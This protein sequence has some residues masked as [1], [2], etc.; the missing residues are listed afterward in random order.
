MA[1]VLPIPEYAPDLSDIAMKTS[2]LISG[3]LPRADGYG[4][5]KSYQELTS[6]LPDVCRGLFYA[7]RT[8]SSIAVFGATATELYLLNNTDFSWTLVSKA[9]YSAV[10]STDNWQFDQF[11]D[12]VIATQI[13]TPPQSFVLS[14]SS[15]FADLGGSPPQA[16]GVA[17]IGG[18]LVLYGLS[19]APKRVQ[20]SDLFAITTW[21]A[22]VGLSD[23]QDFADGGTVRRVAGGDL[24]GIV[25]QDDRIRRMLYQPGSAAIFDFVVLS[26]VH[27]LLGKYSVVPVGDQVFFCSGQGFQK[28]DGSGAIT[29][30]GKE[31]VDRTFLADVDTGNLQLFQGTFDPSSTRI[32]WG[33]KSGA[34][35]SGLFDKLLC[36]DY[37]LGKLGKWS[38]I[39]MSGEFLA[40]VSKPGLTLE[41]LDAIAPTPLNITG[42]ANNGSGAIRLTLNALSN[43]NF[44]IH[45]QNFITVY[46]VVGTTEANNSWAFTIIDSTHIDLVGSTFS[47]AYVSGGHIGGSLDALPFSLDSVSTASISQVAIASSDHTVGYFSGPNIEAILETQEESDDQ[48]LLFLSST[49][50]I[51][52]CA[53]VMVSIG[54]RNTA[55]EDPVYSTENAIDSQQ[56]QAGA[57]VEGRYLKARLRFPAGSTWTYAN[58]VMPDG[59]LAGEI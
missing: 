50:P 40:S 15:Q 38:L 59:Q 10:P 41:N 19:S 28:I 31:R 6:S 13:N 26:R 36:H 33:Y 8:D 32:F 57:L 14:S 25:F 9:T 45:G 3:A 58:G 23:Y 43:S 39:P 21:T 34:G 11:N 12:T 4:P 17:V 53:D 55:Q 27:S 18:F 1:N 52:D 35:Q 37:A 46:G 7:R 49:R 22:G 29:P 20:W 24:F 16:A 5:F 51:T 54:A 42:A 2:T 30:I 44:D 56:G 47:N 48:Q